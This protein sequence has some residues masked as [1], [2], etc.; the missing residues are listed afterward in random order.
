MHGIESRCLS[1]GFIIMVGF[2][3]LNYFVL[4]LSVN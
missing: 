1:N 4:L 3:K 2:Y